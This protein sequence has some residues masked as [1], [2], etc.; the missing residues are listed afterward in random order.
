M[1]VTSSDGKGAVSFRHIT[2]FLLPLVSGLTKT[3]SRPTFIELTIAALAS[4]MRESMR[5]QVVSNAANAQ[6]ALTSAAA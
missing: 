6:L 1:H 3:S 2:Y 5:Q 4:D